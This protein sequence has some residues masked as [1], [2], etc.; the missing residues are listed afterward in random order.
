LARHTGKVL[1][2]RFAG[3]GSNKKM[4]RLFLL[5]VVFILTGVI[6]AVF[7]GYRSAVKSPEKASA[8]IEKEAS[9]FLNKVYQES[10]R[11][12]KKDWSLN[13]DSAYYDEKEKKVVFQ[14]I[15]VTF[16]QKNGGEIYLNAEHG[17]LK[18]DSKDIDVQGKVVV[19]TESYRLTASELSYEDNHRIIYSK[20]P[21]KVTENALNLTADSIY[22]D[23]KA[24]RVN[25]EGNVDGVFS[26]TYNIF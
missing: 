16:F 1:R 13:A 24:N 26:T 7:I 15:S 17:I 5:S 22:V 4:I 3:N 19:E 14:N 20:K 12:G 21:V 25:L 23:L 9:M 18:S 10:V 8:V 2:M 6:I 11:D